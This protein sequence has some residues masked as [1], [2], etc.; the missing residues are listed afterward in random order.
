MTPS[1]EIRPTLKADLPLLLAWRQ[2]PVVMHYFLDGGESW[3]RHLAWWEAGQH[4]S[5]IINYEGRPVG[6][7]HARLGDETEV[8][9]YIGELTLWGRGIG[10]RAMVLFLETEEMVGRWVVASV[11]PHNRRSQ[12]MWEALGFKFVCVKEDGFWLYRRQG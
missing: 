12:H 3:E 2:N 4:R 11:H 7:V 10:Q 9:I 5:Y 1:V 8:G 6:E